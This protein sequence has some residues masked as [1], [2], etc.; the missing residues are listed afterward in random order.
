MACKRVTHGGIE[1]TIRPA[2]SGRAVAKNRGSSATEFAIH[3]VA[4]RTNGCIAALFCCA[5]IGDGGVIVIGPVAM[6]TTSAMTASGDGIIELLS[7]SD[8][9]RLDALNPCNWNANFGMIAK[10]T[11]ASNAPAST[12]PSRSHGRAVDS[13]FTK[14]PFDP[15]TTV[16]R[17]LT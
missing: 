3:S 10:T 2:R 12:F 17:A 7:S 13:K 4:E 11:D 5:D 16:P 14:S 9:L 1:S 8:T 6:V 15:S